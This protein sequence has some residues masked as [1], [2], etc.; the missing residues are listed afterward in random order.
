MFTRHKHGWQID[1]PLTPVRVRGGNSSYEVPAWCL[2]Y[3]PHWNR[4]FFA[5]SRGP[6][7]VMTLVFS[8]D[9]SPVLDLGEAFY[10]RQIGVTNEPWIV[11]YWI[12]NHHWSRAWTGR[13]REL[14]GLEFRWL[15]GRR[16]RQ[17]WRFR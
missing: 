8:W 5:T 4:P 16:Y 9:L 6:R 7:A 11:L 15:G 17:T 2:R 13:T 10:R 1:G 12:E 3:G 14:F